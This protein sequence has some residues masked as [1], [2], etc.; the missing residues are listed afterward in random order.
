MRYQF[1]YPVHIILRRSEEVN[2]YIIQQMRLKGVE[3]NTRD[4]KRFAIRLTMSWVKY[5]RYNPYTELNMEQLWKAE[6]KFELLINTQSLVFLKELSP[7]SDSE[8]DNLL[9]K[10]A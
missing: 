4:T 10:G 7:F 3:I 1:G 2:R 8:L 5:R 9:F 6:T